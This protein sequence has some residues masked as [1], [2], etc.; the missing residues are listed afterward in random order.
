MRLILQA[1]EHIDPL[2][3]EV[4][5]MRAGGQSQY[6]ALLAA[7]AQSDSDALSKL[8]L[9]IAENLKSDLR[10]EVLAERAHVSPRNFAR[11]YAQMRGRTPQKL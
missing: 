5:E 8:E 4:R 1:F 11:V 7:Q 10:V 3:V 9:W 6:S 2:V